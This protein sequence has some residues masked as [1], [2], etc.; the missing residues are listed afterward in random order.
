MQQ[1][2]VDLVCLLNEKNTQFYRYFVVPRIEIT[3]KEYGLRA[4]DSLL[5]PG[6]QLNDLSQLYE[7]ATLFSH[8]SPVADA[9]E[10]Q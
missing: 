10:K 7:T 1:E 4:N 5:A 3:L 6:V 2:H 9:E 8:L